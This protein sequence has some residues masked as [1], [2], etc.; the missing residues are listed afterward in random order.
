MKD[1]GLFAMRRV[2]YAG[3]KLYEI[4]DAATHAQWGKENDDD[5]DAPYIKRLSY[6][7]SLRC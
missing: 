4:K 5:D 7:P 1:A 2:R 3:K 6:F